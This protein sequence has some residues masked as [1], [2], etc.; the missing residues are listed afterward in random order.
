MA[1][2]SPKSSKT[3]CTFE[4]LYKD[5][6]REIEKWSNTVK[7]LAWTIDKKDLEIERLEKKLK[8][9]QGNGVEKKVKIKDP[10]RR[11]FVR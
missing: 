7:N 4:I 5:A 9:L 10:K 8:E 11:K 3:I 1:S 2:K 6:K